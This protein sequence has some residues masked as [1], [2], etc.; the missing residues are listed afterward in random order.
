MTSTGVGAPAPLGADGGPGERHHLLQAVFDESP[1]AIL[2]ARRTN[3]LVGAVVDANPAA[4][5]L[6]GRA[7]SDLIGS[8]LHAALEDGG[9][10]RVEDAETR[11]EVRIRRGDDSTR[12]VAAIVRPLS[13]AAGR[14]MVVVV[15]HDHTEQR[16]VQ[17]DL[18]R[19]ARHDPLTGLINRG[20]MLRRLADIDPASDGP[21]VAVVFLDLDGF[22]LVND[23]RGHQ[24]G[25]E[26]LVAVA[27][28]IS[29]VVRPEDS[30]ARLGGDEFVV[31]C[32][33][34]AEAADARAIA[35]RVRATLDRPVTI[36]DRSHR[37]SMSLGIA[38]AAADEVLPADLLRQ[39]DM[40]M[41]RAKDAGRNTIRYHSLD[42]DEALAAAERTRVDLNRALTGDEATGGDLPS[43]GVQDSA[44]VL[45][46]QPIVEI[47]SGQVAYVEAL[48]RLR[49]AD[50]SLVYPSQFLPVAARVGLNGALSEWVLRAALRQRALWRVDGLDVP[51]GVNL[52]RGQVYSRSFAGDALRII[53]EEADAPEHV[54]FEMEEFGLLEATGPAQLTLRRLRASGIRLAIDHFGTGYSSL[55][56]L[57]FLGPHRVK[58]D[59]SFVASI[60]HSD[61]DRAIVTAAITAAHALGQRVV[62]EGVET[63]AQLSVLTGLGCDEAQGFLVAR[64]MPAVDLNLCATQWEPGS[65]QVRT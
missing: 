65:L 61:A 55:G 16:S 9:P 54:V 48:T 34:L 19:A 64:V 62:A 15:L 38:A 60:T 52:A 41:Y 27:G 53:A 23:T 25:D 43:E 33:R 45:H 58:I 36:G 18:D 7:P 30:V 20:E 59:R 63:A 5:R 28:R 21:Q 4:G 3:N 51:V 24:V 17:D 46:F 8:D 2:R 1:V 13:D 12:W 6:L 44:L 29:H 35:E 32:P 47:D 39:A 14:D 42:M 10:L 11:T 56:A 49:S 37:I 57:R 40:A 31:L 26:L 50:G 22:K